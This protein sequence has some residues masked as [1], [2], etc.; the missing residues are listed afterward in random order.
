MKKDRIKIMKKT[1]LTLS[2]MTSL[3]VIASCTTVP[4]DKK[5]T[6]QVIPEPK[7]IVKE[8]PKQEAPKYPQKITNTN[9]LTQFPSRLAGFSRQSVYRYSAGLDYVLANYAIS[10]KQH[11]IRAQVYRY[12]ATITL[13]QQFDIELKRLLGRLK[14]VNIQS[15]SAGTEVIND[16][17]T[18]YKEIRYF[19][20]G[21]KSETLFGQLILQQRGKQFFRVR[22][23]SPQSEGQST[24]PKIQALLKAV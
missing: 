19:F 5:E 13:E 10:N 12:P 17:F 8:Q 16:K 14:D 22:S 15:K 4:E 20:K 2:A 7:P 3:F 6:P 24:P 21:K 9:E 18:R 1:I 23:S 11:R